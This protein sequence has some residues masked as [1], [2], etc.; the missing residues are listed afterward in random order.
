MAIRE[1]PRAAE[2]GIASGKALNRDSNP[3]RIWITLATDC[4][5]MAKRLPRKYDSEKFV[6][7]VRRIDH[8]VKRLNARVIPIDTVMRF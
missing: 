7:S 2:I 1:T 4:P 6:S 5:N 8:I 3:L